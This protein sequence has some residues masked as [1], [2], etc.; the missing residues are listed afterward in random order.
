MASAR[1][2]TSRPRLGF[3][4]LQV[5]GLVKLDHWNWKLVI[6]YYFPMTPN[7]LKDHLKVS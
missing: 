1:D 5:D 4:A 2:G 6:T 3:A 7:Y